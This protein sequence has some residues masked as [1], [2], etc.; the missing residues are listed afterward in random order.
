MGYAHPKKGWQRIG[1][2]TNKNEAIE[3]AFAGGELYSPTVTVGSK[4]HARDCHVDFI[5]DELIVL[6]TQESLG[7]VSRRTAPVHHATL[8]GGRAI[9]KAPKKKQKKSK[10]KRRP[11]SIDTSVWLLEPMLKLN[12]SGK[13]PEPED[14]VEIIVAE[15]PDAAET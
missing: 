3:L 6:K 13:I 4:K 11:F 14:A 12:V 10:I 5:L 2:S 9:S 1:K 15:V 7:K 8:A